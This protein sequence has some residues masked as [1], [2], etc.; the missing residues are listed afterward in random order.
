M[1]EE[2]D[3]F[4]SYDRREGAAVREVAK[5][6]QREG[7]RVW[8]DE[9]ML[10]GGTPFVGEI[11]AGIAQSRSMAVFVGRTGLGFWVQKEA[12]AFQSREG[13]EALPIIPVLLPGCADPPPLTPFLKAYGWVDL[14]G[15]DHEAAL[16]RLVDTLRGRRG[17]PPPV[18]PRRPRKLR[19]FALCLLTAILV[20]SILWFWRSGP[21][22]IVTSA[23][24]DCSPSPPSSG[25]AI[26]LEVENRGWRQAAIVETGYRVVCFREYET[27]GGLEAPDVI[28]DIDL[29][30]KTK[31]SPQRYYAQRR[32]IEVVD[33]GE[34]RSLELKVTA[35]DL[36][37]GF[38][39]WKIAPFFE[40]R[41]GD[42][43]IPNI[44]LMLP[45]WDANVL[46]ESG[47]CND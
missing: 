17:F 2:F 5:H 29:S 20:I 26:H 21:N 22:L 39:L 46:P 11:E 32:G 12:G 36:V 8:Y 27:M 6:L 18:E 16:A 24:A 30:G 43:I 23:K 7:L 15:G 37:K 9:W 38:R 34:K 19:F 3:V 47:D 10:S 42:V 44:K 13:A 45:Y 4:L 25:C 35:K 1:A 41:S 31:P 40:T 33:A 28:G 14:R